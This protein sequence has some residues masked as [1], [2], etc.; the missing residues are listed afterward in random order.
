MKQR[1]EDAIRCLIYW[2][3]AYQHAREKLIETHNQKYAGKMETNY[4]HVLTS[5]EWLKKVYKAET[6]RNVDTI[7]NLPRVEVLN[8][9]V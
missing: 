3:N 7:G 4:I 5:A 8:E 1:L 6:G 9:G 2:S